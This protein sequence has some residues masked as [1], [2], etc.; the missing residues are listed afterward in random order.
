MMD[1]WSTTQKYSQRF[2]FFIELICLTASRKK[3]VFDIDTKLK[4]LLFASTRFSWNR[5]TSFFHITRHNH[6]VRGLI[7]RIMTMPV[8]C[9][10]AYNRE[11]TMVWLING[12]YQRED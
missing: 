11:K 10:M 7:S 1:N 2:L 8:E 4:K 5:S 6:Y 3:S 12:N 9:R